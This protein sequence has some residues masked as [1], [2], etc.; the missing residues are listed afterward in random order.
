[1]SDQNESMSQFASTG[2]GVS[3]SSTFLE[4]CAKV[5][6]NDPSVLPKPGEPLRIGHLSESE[7]MELADALLENTSVTC[8]ELDTENHTKS[9]AEAMAK[10][11]RTSKRLRRIRW[12]KEK[13]VLLF[14]VCTSRKYVTQ[15]TRNGIASYWWAVQ[16]SVRKY[17]DAYQ[18]FT[19]SEFN[20]SSC[21]ATR[22]HSCGC[23]RV[24]I[25]KEH[26]STRAH[27]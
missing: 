7:H 15:G 13:N 10:Y 1:M 16:P 5:R 8:L 6:N 11:V 9:S 4:F 12:P 14:S 19:V 24:W 18:E 2:D 25:E 27:T 3:L 17:V 26:H 23:S 21:P 20:L 22:R